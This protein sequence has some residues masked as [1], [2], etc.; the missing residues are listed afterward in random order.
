MALAG[1][2]MFASMASAG[3]GFVDRHRVLQ[4]VNMMEEEVGAFGHE[5]T[6][7][8]AEEKDSTTAKA[9]SSVHVPHHDA[10]TAAHEIVSISEQW[11][12]EEIR[13]KNEEARSGNKHQVVTNVKETTPEPTSEDGEGEG[14]QAAEGEAGA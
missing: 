8:L 1:A 2:L 9:T 5:Q 13:L 10:S 7:I 3:R 4:D 14:E 12:D 6:V 11:T